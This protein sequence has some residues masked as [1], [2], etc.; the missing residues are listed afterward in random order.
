MEFLDTTHFFDFSYIILNVHS[1]TES[2]DNAMFD[3]IWLKY[4]HVSIYRDLHSFL[5]CVCIFFSIDHILS[6]SKISVQLA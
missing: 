3:M 6:K 4:V 2:W 5:L 1:K